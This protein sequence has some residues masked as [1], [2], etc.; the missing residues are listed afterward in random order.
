MLAENGKFALILPA[1]EFEKYLDITQLYL[2]RRCDVYSIEGGAIKRILGE[3]AKQ[4]P[5]EIRHESLAIE[6]E[7]RGE[8]SP[9]YRELTKDFYLKF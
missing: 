3:F 6:V 1:T 7:K 9:A 2:V 5:T 8:F 4:G